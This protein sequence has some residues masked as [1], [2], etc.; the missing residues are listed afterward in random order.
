MAAG[1]G[2][3]GRF[4]VGITADTKPLQRDLNRGVRRVSEF[5][6]SF[7]KLTLSANR[8]ARPMANFTKRVVSLRGAMAALAGGGAFG[9][10]IKRSTDLG[11]SL[12]EASGRVG[13]SVEQFQELQ[14]VFEGDGLAADKFEKAMGRLANAVTQ[15]GQGLSTYTR[16]FE[17]LGVEFRDQQTGALRGAAEILSDLSDAFPTLTSQTE[18]LGLVQQIF[19]TRSAAVLT[20]LDRGSASL[21]RQ[22]E[23]MRSLGVVSDRNAATLKALNQ[24]FTDLGNVVK[25]SLANAIAAAS[26]NIRDLVARMQELAQKHTPGAI[27]GLVSIGETTASVAGHWRALVAIWVGSRFLSVPSKLRTLDAL[28][29]GL[30]TETISWAAATKGILIPALTGIGVTAL[31]AI[32]LYR[33]QIKGVI[34]EIREATGGRKSPARLD[35]N[36]FVSTAS[37]DRLRDW[38]QRYNQAQVDLLHQRDKLAGYRSMNFGESSTDIQRALAGI[39]SA[40]TRINELLRERPHILQAIERD[41]AKEQEMAAASAASAATGSA[42][43]R[44]GMDIGSRSA[45]SATKLLEMERTRVRALAQSEGERLLYAQQFTRE[46][47]T[48]ESFAERFLSRQRELESLTGEI[49]G[50]QLL[51]ETYTKRGQKGLADEARKAKSDLEQRRDLIRE[52]RIEYDRIATKAMDLSPETALPSI[53]RQNVESLYALAPKID[54]WRTKSERFGESLSRSFSGLDNQI[55]SIIGNTDSWG[56][57]LERIGRL[58]VY[59]GT[60]ALLDRDG[61]LGV[62]LGAGRKT[63]APGRAIGGRMGA[64]TAYWAGE[65]GPELILPK[66]DAMAV[67]MAGNGSRFSGNVSVT[68]VLENAGPVDAS[69]VDR[70]SEAA[71]AR[72]MAVL[73][74]RQYERELQRRDG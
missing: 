25:T 70:V 71:A 11:A 14:R 51:I 20:V 2:L 53:A 15:A 74:R 24:D 41:R 10:V 13:L 28:I 5:E 61:P 4:V 56:D 60:S 19:G 33:D 46:L 29:K 18:K 72:V 73:G 21:A 9:A 65:R 22:R 30:K 50:Q 3:I 1:M 57:A 35:P 66:T 34:E 63:G 54:E 42:A 67:P 38:T 31:A 8:V 52:V 23:E 47:A 32:V 36:A 7:R 49:S 55:K 16:A 48:Q 12:V 69:V 68:T 37:N 43:L 45:A 26:G 59:I 27:E 6:R 62:A 39:E 17:Q 44:P 58:L 40:E 64:G